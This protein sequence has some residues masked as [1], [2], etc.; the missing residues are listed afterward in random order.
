MKMSHLRVKPALPIDRKEH[1][2][3]GEEAVVS[4]VWSKKLPWLDGLVERKQ[5]MRNP[6]QRGVGPGHDR[7]LVGFCG[8]G[9]WVHTLEDKQEEYSYFVFASINFA[10]SLF[11]ENIINPRHFRVIAE[12]ELKKFAIYSGYVRDETDVLERK[13]KAMELYYTSGMDCNTIR[14]TADRIENKLNQECERLGGEISNAGPG[15]LHPEL[16]YQVQDGK[17]IFFEVEG[18]RMNAAVESVVSMPKGKQKKKALRCLIE[19]YACAINSELKVYEI[20]LQSCKYTSAVPYFARKLL[21][22]KS[23]LNAVAKMFKSIEKDYKKLEILNE[24]PSFFV[25]DVRAARHLGFVD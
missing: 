1:I 5:E 22:S 18:I 8:N 14:N 2:F 19:A 23:F 12:G 15:I 7:A 4:R 3:T 21:E 6:V 16:N 20:F 25:K 10:N 24:A 9:N 17:T 13:R 11:P